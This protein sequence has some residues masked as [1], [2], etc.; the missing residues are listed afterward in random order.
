MDHGAAFYNGQLY[1][2]G[3]VYSGG[4]VDIFNPVTNTWSSGAA[5]PT[6]NIASPVDIAVGNNASGQQVAVLF[7][8]A[9]FGST[10]QLHIYNFVTNSWSTA[11]PPAGFPAGGIWAHDIACNATTC[12]ITGG[13]TVPGGGDLNTFYAYNVAAN[14]LTALPPFTTARDFH[15]S[16]F[17]NNLLCIAGG[18]TATDAELN[19][20]QCF[21]F[22][23]NAWR[24]ENADLGTLPT[25]WWGMADGVVTSGGQQI[26]VL[27]GG[28]GNGFGLIPNI[29]VYQGGSWQVVGT[30]P[31][32]YRL[33][34]AALGNRFYIAAGSAGGWNPSNQLTILQLGS[35]CGN[36][37]PVANAGL[38]QTVVINTPVTLNGSG[39]SDPEGQTITYAWTQTGGP[40]VTLIGPATVNP[41][42]IPIDPGVYTFSLVVNDGTDDSA[43]DDVVVTVNPPA[44]AYDLHFR[45]DANRSDLCINSTTGQYLYATVTGG[46]ATVVRAG[47]GTLQNWGGTLQWTD[48]NGVWFTATYYMTAVPRQAYA[49][50]S[51]PSSMLW[52]SNTTNNGPCTLTPPI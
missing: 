1:V 38:D 51:S 5:E 24:A 41:T 49:M 21:D 27:A 46:V 28:S 20:T 50:L 18:T 29:A 44:P 4:S 23:T 35:G 39:S 40:A 19:S 30:T 26:P 13:A 36:Q 15:A 37:P 43:P 48:T 10:N 45:D 25:T 9:T 42:F 34:G 47:V 12:Y 11:A 7:P 17:Y 2:I 33:E 6:P 32:I 16:F 31:S 8:N 3:G 52:D 22:T 14:T